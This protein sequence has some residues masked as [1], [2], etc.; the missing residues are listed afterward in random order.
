MR[1]VPTLKYLQGLLML[2]LLIVSRR[3]RDRWE[4]ACD[5]MADACDFVDASE[6][7]MSAD[8]N[9]GKPELRLVD[10]FPHTLF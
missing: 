4:A 7:R 2:T 6:R 5:Q 10:R 3:Y 8:R 1:E 9:G